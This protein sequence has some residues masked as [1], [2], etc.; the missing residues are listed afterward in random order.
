MK[1]YY[2]YSIKFLMFQGSNWNIPTQILFF[3]L[4]FFWYDLLSCVSTP[5]KV[6]FGKINFWVHF[7]HRIKIS[8]NAFEFYL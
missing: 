3:F 5:Q 2:G 7:Y 1:S 4:S 6:D 8:W